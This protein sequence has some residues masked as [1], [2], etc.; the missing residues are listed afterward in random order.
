MGT[1]VTADKQLP[2]QHFQTTNFVKALIV[3]HIFHLFW[4]T[5]FFV[6]TGDFLV[7]GAATSWFY[8]RQTPFS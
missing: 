5:F 6:E 3:L 8:R 4:V 1:P 2:F 7:S